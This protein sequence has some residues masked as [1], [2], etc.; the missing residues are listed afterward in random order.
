MTV[1]TAVSQTPTSPRISRRTLL[2]AGLAGA[3]ALALYAS[4]IERHWIEVVETEVHLRGLPE[5]FDGLRVAQ[6]S[7]I[8]MDEYTEPFFVREAVRRVN[9]LEPDVVLL[10]GDFVSEIPRG[11]DFAIGAAW[12]CA[13]LLRELRCSQLYGILGNHDIVVGAHPVM[14]ALT[15][16]GI[17]ML[18]NG[19]LPI[20]RPGGRIWLA[21]FD[22][23]LCGMPDAEL[24]IP[25]KIRG[26]A[27]EP[28]ILMCH[29][30]DYADTLLKHPAGQAVDWM[31]S[32]H[33][34]GGQ[35]R[36]PWVGATHLPALGRKYVEGWFRFG[37]M[38]LYVN[39]GLGTVGVPFRFDCPPEITLHTLRTA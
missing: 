32:G 34:H 30:P 33:T 14:E 2:K 10:T 8:H 16:H 7:D 28:L 3:A 19:Y 9:E 29:T 17:R 20:E 26:V 13:Q 6:L 25:G 21:G 37:S 4:E 23:P 39:R 35:I 5:A 27:G 24:A 15:A 38:Q 12:Q 18:R 31:L 22:D 36:L 11:G 1:A